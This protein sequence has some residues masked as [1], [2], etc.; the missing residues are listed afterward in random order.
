MTVDPVNKALRLR[1]VCRP[2]AEGSR[3]ACGLEIATALGHARERMCAVGMQLDPQHQPP[4][5]LLDGLLW[6]GD[7]LE[8]RKMRVQELLATNLGDRDRRSYALAEPIERCTQAIANISGAYGKTVSRIDHAELLATVAGRTVNRSW[9]AA[10]LGSASMPDQHDNHRCYLTSRL[11]RQGPN[12]RLV[13]IPCFRIIVLIRQR[14]CALRQLA[15]PKPE[16]NP[17]SR[18]AIRV[19]RGAGHLRPRRPTVGWAGVSTW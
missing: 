6:P 19:V 8:R 12:R 4:G 15:R 11:D 2:P 17:V 18:R 5:L 10:R 3:T 16:S 9:P 13:T 1:V 7:A 14:R